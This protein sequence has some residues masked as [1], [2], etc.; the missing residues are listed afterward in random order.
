MLLIPCGEPDGR[1]DGA[2]GN[3]CGSLRDTAS[4]RAHIKKPVDTGPKPVVNR[5]FP[6]GWNRGNPSRLQ[7]RTVEDFPVFPLLSLN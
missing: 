7:K 2:M 6:R 3:R 1:P 5:H 4:D